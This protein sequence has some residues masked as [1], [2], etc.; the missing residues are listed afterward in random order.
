MRS[1]VYGVI[2]DTHNHSWRA[3]SKVL[4]SG[5]NSRLQQTLDETRRCAD[6]V[7]KAG[8]NLLIHCGDMFHVRGSVTP[9]VLNPTLALYKELIADGMNI[10]LA[11]GN[12]DAE[13]NSITDLGSAITA[14]R[15]VGCV[16]INSNCYIAPLTLTSGGLLAIPW[17]TKE[18]VLE[19]LGDKG[20]CSVENRAKTDVFIHAGIDGVIKGLPNHGLTVEDLSAFG[21]RRIF[22]G[23]YHNHKNL[24]SGVYSVGALTH[25]TWSDVGSKAGFLLVTDDSVEWRASRA[26]QFIEIDEKT[27]PEDIPLLADGNYVRARITTNKD[28]EVTE[29]RNYLTG[30]GAKGVSL[31]C[32]S[33]SEVIRTGSSVKAG[34]SLEVSVSEYI[35]SQEIE[36]KKDVSKLC[37]EILTDVRSVK[38]AE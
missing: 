2:S 16:T 22:A 20:Y 11:A 32:N 17:S 3:F 12:H 1:T 25:Q 34:S 19:A 28:S 36:H 31:I 10:V 27:S 14:L 35:E 29:F 24:G 21:Y 4:P 30:C 8:G 6:E 18:Q 5:V 33:A 38:G 37:A 7:K 26:P 15:E 23:H 13:D 9:S